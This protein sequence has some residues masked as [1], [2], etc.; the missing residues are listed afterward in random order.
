MRP[1][2]DSKFYKK[3]SIAYHDLLFEYDFELI[4]IEDGRSIRWQNGNCILGIVETEDNYEISIYDLKNPN[5]KLNPNLIYEALTGNPM[6]DWMGGANQIE[7]YA[8]RNKYN[9]NALMI[10]LN[11]VF[12]GDFSWIDEYLRLEKEENVLFQE[13]INLENNHPLKKMYWKRPANWKAK[14]RQYLCNR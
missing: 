3:V 14:M 8:N 9:A 4:S 12:N 13:L 5:Y 6:I 7:Y 2:I 11:I 1:Q 10:T